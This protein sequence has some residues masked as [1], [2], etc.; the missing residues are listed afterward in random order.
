MI[1]SISPSRIVRRTES[2]DGKTFGRSKRA[3]LLVV[4]HTIFEA[5]D[6][7]PTEVIRI[8]SARPASKNERRIYENE[9]G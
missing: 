2:R 8:I 4:V 5:D 7:G 6:D 9:D 3:T 1:R